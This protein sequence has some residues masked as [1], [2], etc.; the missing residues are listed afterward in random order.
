MLF[1]IHF[2]EKK[3]K[4]LIDY[5]IGASHSNVQPKVFHH[6]KPPFWNNNPKL[7]RQQI[8]YEE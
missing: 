5:V 6:E 2:Y 3:T 7:E 4:K 8:H 1:N